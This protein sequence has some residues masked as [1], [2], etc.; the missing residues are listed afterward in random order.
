L[1][2]DVVSYDAGTVELWTRI[3]E[4]VEG[5]TV[6][7][8][9]GGE[10]QIGSSAVWDG[11]FHGVWHLS[12]SDIARDST[13]FT[14]H[15]MATSGRVPGSNAG[16]FGGAR[17]LDGDDALTTNGDPPNGA[18]DFGSSSFSYSLW[19]FQDSNL[20]EF[21]TPMWKGGTSAGEPGY[22]WLLGSTW[23]AKVHD[24]SEQSEAGLGAATQFHDRWVHLVAVV[25]RAA[26]QITAYADGGAVIGSEQLDVGNLSNDQQFEIGRTDSVSGPFAGMIDEVRIYEGTL[27]LD[28]I[29]AE[30]A[31]GLDPDFLAVGNEEKKP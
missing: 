22:C 6:Y 2:V 18:V 19:V 23:S 8:Y 11:L 10:D 7:L 29:R 25:D 15:M 5:T 24:G 20:G 28:W 27:T 30:H 31:N 14:N 4:L 1:A 9:Y 3:P 16:V 13:S 12:E 17:A 21:D 26:G